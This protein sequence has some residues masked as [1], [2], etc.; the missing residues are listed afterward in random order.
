MRCDSC[1]MLC[2]EERI[3]TRCRA[4]TTCVDA[5]PCE[6]DAGVG[7]AWW[8]CKHGAMVDERGVDSIEDTN[9]RSMDGAVPW[10]W[11]CH[12]IDGMRGQGDDAEIHRFEICIA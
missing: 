9:H 5:M 11:T 3:P 12:G 6:D 1:V 4:A 2:R 10:R 7:Y 8:R